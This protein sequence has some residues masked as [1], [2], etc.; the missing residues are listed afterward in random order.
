M[1]EAGPVAEI[2]TD[3]LVMRGW[4]E[5]D[6]APWTSTRAR[7]AGMWCTGKDET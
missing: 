5:S 2:G 7:Y 6:L 4:R 3:R 1:I